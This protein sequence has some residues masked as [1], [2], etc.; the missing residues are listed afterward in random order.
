MNQLALCAVALALVAGGDQAPPKQESTGDVT[1]L[2]VGTPSTLRDIDAGAVRGIPTRLAW[3]MDDKYLYLRLST[4][5][6]WAN[7]TVRHILIDVKAAEPRTLGD[8][9]GWLGRYWNAKAGLVS[10]AIPTWK[11]SVDSRDEQV[12]TTNV[13]REGNIGQFTSD[14]GSGL[15]ETVRKA[16]Q[17]QQKTL[18][19]DYRLSGHTISSSINEHVAAGRTYAWAPAPRPFMAFVTEKGRLA[20]MDS[21]GRTVE[22]KDT[23]DVRLPAWSESGLRLA[24]VQQSGRESCSI[25]IV[26]VR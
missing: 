19:E 24:F 22:L 13:P 5:D 7:E 25:K 10:P 6:R 15:E 9:P 17:A 14:P 16:A 8:E 18:F 23:K 1:R 11:I 12:R 3:S 2:S 21:T 26:D 4:F 20:L